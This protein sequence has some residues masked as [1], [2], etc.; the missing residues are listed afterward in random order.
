MLLGR[1]VLE[2]DHPA[3]FDTRVPG[4]GVQ[5]DGVTLGQQIGEEGGVT[6]QSTRVE[7]VATLMA[8]D[9]FDIFCLVHV[10]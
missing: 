9:D 2:F 1:Q 3:R 10:E 7:L 6:R 5:F 4:A 8:E